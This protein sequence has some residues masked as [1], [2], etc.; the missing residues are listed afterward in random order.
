MGTLH[1]SSFPSSLAPLALTVCSV[2]TVPVNEVY[3]VLSASMP[4]LGES[5]E[6]CSPACEPPEQA[7]S[8]CPT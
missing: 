5:E 1:T 8:A 3:P 7:H 2:L 6:C 4:L